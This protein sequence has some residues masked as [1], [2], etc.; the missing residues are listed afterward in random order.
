MVVYQRHDLTG[1]SPI[2]DDVGVPTPNLKMGE[3]ETPR[4]GLLPIRSRAG[5]HRVVHLMSCF[6]ASYPDSKAYLHTR[7][8]IFSH[9]NECCSKAK[10]P[11]SSHVSQ[12][13]CCE[14]FVPS[15]SSVFTVLFLGRP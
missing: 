7:E 3:T 9:Q 12:T 10:A 15:S 13:C 14:D 2:S 11:Q 1:L 6:F 5:S 4:G 8:Y